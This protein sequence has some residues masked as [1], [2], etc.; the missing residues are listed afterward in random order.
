VQRWE[1]AV[2]DSLSS[3]LDRVQTVLAARTEQQIDRNN[4]QVKLFAAAFGAMVNNYVDPVD[5]ANL[6]DTAIAGMDDTSEPT[7]FRDLRTLV[8][9]GISAMV[10]AVDPRGAYLDP[11]LYAELQV[12]TRGQFGGAG[13]EITMRNGVVTIVAPI[14]GGPAARAGLRPGDQLLAIDDKST[15]GV[16]LVRAVRG[17]RGRVGTNVVLTLRRPGFTELLTQPITREVIVLRPVRSVRIHDTLGYL[18]ISQF[19]E[20]AEADVR[21]ALDSLRR[22]G[23]LDGLVFDLRS[24]PGGLFSQAVRVADIFLDAGTIVQ[25]KGRV[26]SENQTFYATKEGPWSDVPMAILVD[27]GTAA[28]SEIVAAALQAN[29]RALVIGTPT[30][31]RGTIQTIIPIGDQAAL[32]LTTTRA[33][34][35]TGAPIDQGVQPDIV[36]D[37]EPAAGVPSS[38]DPVQDPMV[39]AAIGVLSRPVTD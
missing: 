29:N 6:I 24:N 10:S 3:Q 31:R 14:E 8:E 30:F 32:R 4:G 25:T 5:P 13:L 34:S 27:R 15:E 2:P 28:G 26:G 20:R 37:S 21:D 17:L 39:A 11:E 33:Y 38:Q 35:P 18:R 7:T 23:A 19:G 16:D 36:I 12:G 22:D 9:A 1:T